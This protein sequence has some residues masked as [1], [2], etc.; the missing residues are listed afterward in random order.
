MSSLVNTSWIAII[1]T[2]T[3]T[4]CQDKM[5]IFIYSE[6][7]NNSSVSVRFTD[8][9]TLKICQILSIDT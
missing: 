1:P 2:A 6:D 7:S 9:N 4:V 8:S 5:Q 3:D